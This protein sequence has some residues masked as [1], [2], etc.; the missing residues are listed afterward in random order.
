MKK[1][2]LKLIFLSAI[3]V[4]CVVGCDYDLAPIKSVAAYPPDL[5][6]E[7]VL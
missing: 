3:A 7:S 1:Y 6:K 2:K 5:N 4:C